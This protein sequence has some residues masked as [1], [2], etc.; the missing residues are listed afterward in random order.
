[1]LQTNVPLIVAVAATAEAAYATAVEVEG[2]AG[3]DTILLDIID[4]TG[5]V[6]SISLGSVRYTDFTES[7]LSATDTVSAFEGA[8]GTDATTGAILFNQDV[9]SA[10][11]VT[12]VEGNADFSATDGAVTWL[13]SDLSITARAAVLDGDLAK[14]RFVTLTDNAGTDFLF[15]QGGSVG[16]GTDDDLIV[17]FG[18]DVSAVTVA[19]GTAITVAIA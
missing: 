15:I 5:A 6:S 12:S 10:V 18:N 9:V 14:G 16:G 2:G 19:G 17:K 8:V 1:M 7:N 11:R 4:V 3:A 13:G